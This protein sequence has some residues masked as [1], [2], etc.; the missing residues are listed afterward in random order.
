MYPS[1]F[2][3]ID[4]V[5]TGNNIRRLRLERGLSV[6]DIQTY[7]GF[8]EPRAVYKWQK[9]E[10]LPTVDNLYALGALLEVPMDRILVPSTTDKEQRD[11]SCCSHLF[12]LAVSGTTEVR[13]GKAHFLLTLPA[14]LATGTCGRN[15]LVASAIQAIRV[16]R[17]RKRMIERIREKNALGIWHR[18]VKEALQ[19]S[20]AEEERI[21]VM[22]ILFYHAAL[23]FICI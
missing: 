22:H 20:T 8:E 23:L 17:E 19:S 4:L 16:G 15:C 11:Q 21:A 7:F 14:A 3:V 9:G 10:A 12:F 6:R 13:S 1:A 2:P 5:A 18:K